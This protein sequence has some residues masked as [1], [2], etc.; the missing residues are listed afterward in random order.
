[1]ARNS[2]ALLNEYGLKKKIVVYVQDEGVNLNVM[3]VALKSM[4]NCDILG[5]D[6][7]F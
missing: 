3:I 4:V 7:S 6:E 2:I 1:L 5:S